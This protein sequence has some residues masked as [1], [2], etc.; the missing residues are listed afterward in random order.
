[1]LPSPSFKPTLRSLK[2]IIVYLAQPQ[3]FDDIF[4]SRYTIPD[5]KTYEKAEAAFALSNMNIPMWYYYAKEHKGI[6]IEYDLTDFNAKNLSSPEVIL[7]PVIYPDDKTANTYRCSTY[8]ENHENVMLV[9]N[10]LV[11]NKN[12]N[13]EKEWRLISVERP[14]IYQ[15]LKIQAIYFGLKT[16]E[17]DKRLILQFN[18]DYNLGI[19]IYQMTFNN[20]KFEAKNI[21]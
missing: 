17:V 7:L 21:I 11:K 20:V 18:K 8:E 5:L 19:D 14:N 9:R 12:W 13:F 2:Q 16:E 1:M 15:H 10:A 3:D 4:D 6:C